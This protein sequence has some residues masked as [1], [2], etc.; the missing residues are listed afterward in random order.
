MQQNKMVPV[1]HIL[2]SATTISI[3]GA[4]IIIIMD[5]LTGHLGV[6]T[7]DSIWWMCCG[8][9]NVWFVSKK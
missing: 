5:S 2:Y 6:N 3:I 1:Q 7:F 9:F 4:L 8:A